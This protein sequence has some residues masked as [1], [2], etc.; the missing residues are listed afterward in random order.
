[1]LESGALKFYGGLAVNGTRD[2]KPTAPFFWCDEVSRVSPVL[3]VDDAVLGDACDAGVEG[4]AG[5]G[6]ARSTGPRSP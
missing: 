3:G 2:A 4:V 1:M 5:G 6:V